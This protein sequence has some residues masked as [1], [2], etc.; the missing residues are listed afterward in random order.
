MTQLSQKY[1]SLAARISFTETAIA[2]CLKGSGK[3]GFDCPACNGAQTL[4]LRPD[5]KGGRCGVC[6]EGFD[7]WKLVRLAKG[8]QHNRAL[9]WLERAA[10]EKERGAAVVHTSSLFNGEG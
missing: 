8:L 6:G 10:E 7:T 3:L 4:K 2:L 5:R 9:I 1:E